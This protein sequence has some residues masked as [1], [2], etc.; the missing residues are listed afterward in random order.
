MDE[1]E[2]TGH[3]MQVSILVA[4]ENMEYVL[5]V[6]REPF[7]SPLSCSH[8]PGMQ[9]S[10]VFFSIFL[11]YLTL[12]VLSFSSEVPFEENE[13]LGH[14][15]HVWTVNVDASHPDTHT[16]PLS[17][18]RALP[19]LASSLHLLDISVCEGLIFDFWLCLLAL[20]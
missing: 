19:T 16:M 11:R 9:L 2:L 12:H 1:N 14:M 17:V 7:I 5:L 20:V 8:V 6:H 10:R 15:L 3:C 18:P 4:D 13:S